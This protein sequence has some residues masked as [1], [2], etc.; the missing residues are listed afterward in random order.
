MREGSYENLKKI[1]N[2]RF[3]FKCSHSVT[4]RVVRL[5]GCLFLDPSPLDTSQGGLTAWV[6]IAASESAFGSGGGYSVDITV[7][8]SGLLGSGLVLQNN[9][10]DNLAIDSDGEYSFSS[11]VKKGSEYNITV[12][13]QPSD[14]PQVCLI[15]G[16]SGT[17]TENTAIKI[18]INCDS[19]YVT[20]GGTITGLTGSGLV[21][22]NNGGDDLSVTGNG[23]F[24]FSDGVLDGEDYEVTILTPPGNPPQKCSITG[25]D[26]TASAG[27]PVEIT[28]SCE[29]STWSSAERLVKLG[30]NV[31]EPLF[32]VG[33]DGS[34]RAHL[35]YVDSSVILEL[36]YY[37]K[38]L[39]YQ[40]GS[41][42]E[43]FNYT[44]SNHKFDA[45]DLAVNSDGNALLAVNNFE[46]DADPGLYGA[47]Y[48]PS[49]GWPDAPE[50][51]Y[52]YDVDCFF[53]VYSVIWESGNGLIGC[54]E[55]GINYY[56]YTDGLFSALKDGGF[57]GADYMDIGSSRSG[58]AAFASTEAVNSGNFIGLHHEDDT[59][60]AWTTVTDPDLA[61]VQHTN[62]SIAVNDSGKILLAR[63][64]YSTYSSIDVYTGDSKS[65]AFIERVAY[66]G[67]EGFDTVLDNQNRGFLFWTENGSKLLWSYYVSGSVDTTS[68]TLLSLKTGYIDQDVI[69][70]MNSSGKGYLVW[71]TTADSPNDLNLYAATIDTTTGKVG[72]PEIIHTHVFSGDANIHVSVA[73]NQSGR[74]VVAL[75][76]D[77]E[78]ASGVYYLWASVIE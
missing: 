36:E 72:N 57:A 60:E 73:V 41:W 29:N 42:S 55:G 50:L 12:L 11:S 5:S 3:Y 67:I 54:Y 20:V 32:R 35:V 15:E 14:P 17:I 52:Y 13:E 34:T 46:A 30:N 68:Q 19:A 69:A 48:D 53:D 6:G 37:V 24:S 23:D 65:M 47:D 44:E 38:D 43:I 51:S 76:A 62:S 25:G 78:G 75:G 66:A 31:G 59:N 1:G 33:I 45:I 74:G 40:N 26:G 9:G 7:I 70:A 39:L 10:E 27:I 49:S 77:L 22:Q 71:V 56:T 18:S 21:L 28:I 2:H 8:I 4:T 63:K 58:Y 16:G 61:K 64:Y